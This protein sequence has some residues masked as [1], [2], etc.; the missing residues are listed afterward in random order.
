MG[1]TREDNGRFLPGCKPGPGRPRRAIE[2]TY[3]AA[4]SEACP[5]DRWKAIVEQAV[6]DAEEGDPKARAWLAG[7]LAGPPSGDGLIQLAAH[8]AAGTDPIEAIADD[9]ASKALIGS[10]AS[11]LRAIEGPFPPEGR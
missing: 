11:S 6:H 4:I 2:A 3:L 8:E 7:Y 10:L 9:L 5:P 1:D